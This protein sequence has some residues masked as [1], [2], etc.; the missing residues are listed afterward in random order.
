M[1]EILSLSRTQEEIR[2]RFLRWATS[3]YIRGHT[4]R[5]AQPAG[6]SPCV[7]PMQQHQDNSSDKGVQEQ[8]LQALRISNSIASSAPLIGARQ[9]TA[10]PAATPAEPVATPSH[11]QQQPQHQQQH[12]QQISN[13][14][15]ITTPTHPQQG[16]SSSNNSRPTTT[17]ATSPAFVVEQQPSQA[18]VPRTCPPIFLLLINLYDK[19]IADIHTTVAHPFPL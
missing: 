8:Q 7:R 11:R 5:P 18:P 15:S 16:H 19:A 10:A 6:S 13:S 4:A 1:R 3:K 2:F 17:A 12:R 9:P 14:S